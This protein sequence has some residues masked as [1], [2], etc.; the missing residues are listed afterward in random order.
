MFHFID[1]IPFRLI[2]VTYMNL[3]GSIWCLIDDSWLMLYVFFLNTFQCTLC[4]VHW[5][6]VW[7]QLML[8][9]F[10]SVMFYGLNLCFFLH[11]FVFN[12]FVSQA[13]WVSLVLRIDVCVLECL[14]V[15]GF[16]Y[17]FIWVY[18]VFF[19]HLTWCMFHGF[20]CVSWIWYYFNY[21]VLYQ[22]KWFLC[23]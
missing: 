9:Y 14:S 7:V 20:S 15:C 8:F 6:C 13:I 21:L 18:C 17:I 19:L 22:F 2:D 16:I 1:V 5:L 12:G 3:I 10:D 23:T 4:C 11:L